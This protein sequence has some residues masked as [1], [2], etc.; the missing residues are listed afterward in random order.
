L[1]AT[2]RNPSIREI[3][4]CGLLIAI[5]LHEP[6]RGYCERLMQLGVLC[7]ETHS[8]VIRLAPPLVISK[9]DLQWACGQLR[10]VFA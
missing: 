8:H 3:R 1:R 5:D 2:L 6:A 7:K 10:A 9:E 4:G